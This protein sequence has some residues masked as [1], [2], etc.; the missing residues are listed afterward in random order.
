MRRSESP[1]F[2][3][4]LSLAFPLLLGGLV[5][6]GMVESTYVV[7]TV[8]VASCS[9]GARV[10]KGDAPKGP[11]RETPDASESA[12]AAIVVTPGVSVG[13]A[14]EDEFAQWTP[15]GDVVARVP[16]DLSLSIPPPDTGWPGHRPSSARAAEAVRTLRSPRAPPRA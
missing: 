6:L 2:I 16:L 15:S 14:L 11:S 1:K 12:D 13:D 9:D 8:S 4:R 10:A 7:E 3:L 5:T